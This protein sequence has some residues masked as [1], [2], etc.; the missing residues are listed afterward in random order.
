MRTLCTLLRHNWARASSRLQMDRCG[1]APCAVV[2]RHLQIREETVEDLARSSR[3]LEGDGPTLQS[4]AR[5][6]ARWGHTF[7]LRRGPSEERGRGERKQLRREE[8]DGRPEQRRIRP[9]R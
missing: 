3:R 1:W 2:A 5:I 6:R 8:R 4:V 7:P 9:R